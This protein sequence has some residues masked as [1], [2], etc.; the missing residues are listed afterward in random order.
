MKIRC[1]A[2]DLDQTTLDGEGRLSPANRAALERAISQ[3]V[4]IVIASGRP[5]AALPEDVLSVP[6]IEYAITSNGAAVY[7]LPDGT[8]LHRCTLTPDSVEEVLS[9][10]AELPLAYEVFVDGRGYAQADYVRA[11]E[12]YGAC[13]RAADYVRRTRQPVEDITAFIRANRDKLDSLDLVTDDQ[14]LRQHL[15]EEIL[16][17]VDDLYITTSMRYLLELSN[18]QCGKHAGVRFVADRLGLSPEQMAAFGDGDNDADMLSY[19]G[20]GIAMANASPLCLAAARHVTLDHRHDGVAHGI[21]TILD[22]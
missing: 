12:R 15:R 7:Y 9:R 3:G 18:R 20:Q 4:H 5:Y 11:P 17:D 14:S 6:G 8:C 16:C 13:G 2:L 22:I 1:I 19:V 10:T 21:R